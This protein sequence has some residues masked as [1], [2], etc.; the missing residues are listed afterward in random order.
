MAIA[1]KVAQLP[2]LELYLFRNA[3]NCIFGKFGKFASSRSKLSNPIQYSILV[4]NFPHVAILDFMTVLRQ[5][6]LFWF[7]EGEVLLSRKTEQ[8][9]NVIESK[10]A[11]RKNNQK[12]KQAKIKSDMSTF[13]ISLLDQDTISN[14]L[15]LIF[16]KSGS[17]TKVPSITLLQIYSIW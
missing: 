3:H 11:A 13:S 5:L 16:C 9:H 8:P 15:S 6:M 10:V 12:W 2:L 1:V 14:S 4:G 7:Q 17:L